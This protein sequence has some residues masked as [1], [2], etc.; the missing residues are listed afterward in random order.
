MC[1]TLIRRRHSCMPSSR[2]ASTTQSSPRLR[3]QPPKTGYNECW[4]LPPESSATPGSSTM[5]FRDW[6]IR[7]YTGWT[8]LSESVTSWACWLIGVCSVKRQCTCPTVVSR[9]PKSQHVGIYGLL[10]VIS[11]SFHDIVLLT[12]I[13]HSLS[14]VRWR[15]TLC[16]MIC[17][18]PLSAQQPS[19]NCWKHTFSLP[20]STFSTLGVSHVM[21]YINL[22][23]LLTYLLDMNLIDVN[24]V[25]LFTLC[26][27]FLQTENIGGC[28][29]PAECC[30]Y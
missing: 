18:T 21:H 12:V 2:R 10:H 3:R 20:I 25:L 24:F 6:C 19:D 16:Q 23:Y 13:G 14:L 30:V 22:R 7:S 15:S 17:E 11:W 26:V 5:D 4:M 8:S 27:I 9:S 1:S 29:F 28:R